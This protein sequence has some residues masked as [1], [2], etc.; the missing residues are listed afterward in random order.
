MKV[1]KLNGNKIQPNTAAAI[2]FFDGVHLAHQTL[3]TTM[4][5]LAKQHGVPSAVITFD[6]H[7]KHVLLDIDYYYITPLEDK[8]ETLKTFDVDVVYV[9]E[10]DRQKAGMDPLAFIDSYL[11]PLS[12]LVCGF[13]FTFGK[14]ASG[15]VETLKTYA[16]F[17]TVVVDKLS[18]DGAKIG[19]TV[20]REQIRN[21]RVKDITAT[22]GR[23]YRIKGEI[24]H[25]KKK[26]RTI[27]YPT[28]N[29]DVGA[30]LIPKR[31]VYAS[32]SKIKDTWYKS[33]TSVGYNP[34]LNLND[35]ISVESYLF[36]FHDEVY[37]ETIE[38]VFIERLRDEKRFDSKQALIAAIKQDEK[39][40]LTLLKDVN[41]DDYDG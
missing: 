29:I 38:T 9:I 37:G 25:G 1:V 30:Y 18:H 7:P 14:R 17:K 27:D 36:D 21:G 13:D 20:I 15:T 41:V 11:K 34:T 28:A 2:G 16:P 8:L 10:F 22:L 4:Q 40:T 26:G 24:I 23:H 12:V 5:S 32:M 19:S 3:I 33:M 35:H 39:K 6:K 31:G